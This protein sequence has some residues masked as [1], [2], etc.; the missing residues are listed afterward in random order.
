[1]LHRRHGFFWWRK[2]LVFIKIGGSQNGTKLAFLLQSWLKLAFFLHDSRGAIPNLTMM[3]PPVDFWVV[4]LQIW[5]AVLVL[6][7]H[8]PD[9]RQQASEA[10][11]TTAAN[12]WKNQPS[13]HVKVFA[14]IIYSHLILR[15]QI[16]FQKSK[17]NATIKPAVL[18]ARSP[19]TC[20]LLQCPLFP[21]L[22]QLLE[23]SQ[24]NGLII[25]TF[26]HGHHS[27]LAS[28]S[29]WKSPRWCKMTKTY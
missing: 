19:A 22:Y 28:L 5:A 4:A 10:A 14:L 9:S 11:W 2:T 6:Q 25:E 8:H 7:A 26:L 3:D 17:R 18:H 21:P 27:G 29:P 24:F 15:A 23:Y 20:C 13:N 1:M 12:H 16:Y